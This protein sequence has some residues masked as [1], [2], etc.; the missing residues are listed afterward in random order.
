MLFSPLENLGRDHVLGVQ[1]KF[2]HDVADNSGQ[3]SAREPV[4]VPSAFKLRFDHA[5]TERERIH[6]RPEMGRQVKTA[7]PVAAKGVIEAGQDFTAKLALVAPRGLLQ[8]PQGLL[9]DTNRNHRVRLLLASRG[10]PDSLLRHWLPDYSLFTNNYRV[11]NNQ[12]T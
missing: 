6:E 10:P 7:F 9:R 12:M 3:L 5:S 11:Y 2:D 8:Q 1:R 4:F